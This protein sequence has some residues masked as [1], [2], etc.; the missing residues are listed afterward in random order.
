MNVKE[1]DGKTPLMWA[2]FEGN[3]DCVKAL[4][5]AHANLNAKD[6]KGRTAIALTRESTERVSIIAIC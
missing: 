3:T 2:A 4:I 5:S 6:H 1:S